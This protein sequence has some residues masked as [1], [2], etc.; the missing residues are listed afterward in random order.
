MLTLPNL[1]LCKRPF[2]RL[3]I[4]LVILVTGKFAIAARLAARLPIM[5]QQP[6]ILRLCW[7]L[8]ARFT[9]KTGRSLPK[10]ILTACLKPRLKKAKSSVKLACQS[11]KKPLMS[12][13]Q[14][15][16]RA[17]RWL[18]CLWQNLL[19]AFVLLLRVLAKMAFSVPAILRPRLMQISALMRLPMERCRLMV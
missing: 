8:V 1:R 19:M 6:A 16:P 11:R 7:H 10:I 2:R 9:P 12:N 15:R 3:L 13:S 18:G 17:M 5:T 4:W 14:I